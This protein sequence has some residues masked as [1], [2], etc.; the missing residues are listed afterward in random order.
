[1]P[2]IRKNRIS[3]KLEHQEGIVDDKEFVFLYDLNTSKNLLLHYW[4]YK[5]FDSDSLTYKDSTLIKAKFSLAAR[6]NFTFI[7]VTC[8]LCVIVLKFTMEPLAVMALE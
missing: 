4:K 6:L 5:N 8:I 1:M 7:A 3:L 2:A